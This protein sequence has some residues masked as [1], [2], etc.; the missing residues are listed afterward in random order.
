MTAGEP[1][2]TGNQGYHCQ[3]VRSTERR[4]KT[5]SGRMLRRKTRRRTSLHP[6]PPLG[7]AGEAQRIDQAHGQAED[8]VPRRFAGGR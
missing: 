5:I 6:L 3:N 7:H 4:E 8:R 1:L 2:E